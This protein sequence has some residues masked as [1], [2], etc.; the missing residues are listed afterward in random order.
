VGRKTIETLAR[1]GALDDFGGH[2]AQL[3][4]G[5]EAAWGYAQRT[6]ADDALGQSSLF[7]PHAGDG[8]GEI[9]PA[10]PVV[11]PWSRA[12]TLRN[13]RDLM[14]FYISGHPLEEYR[15]E[16][17]A[18][19]N[20]R[21]GDAAGVEPERDYSVVGIVTA[22]Q[23]RTSRAGKPMAFVSIEDDSGQ[24]EVA[25]FGQTYEKYASAL[26]VDDVLLVRGRVE[27]SGALRMVAREVVPMW[28][29][30]EQLVRAVVLKINADTTDAGRLEELYELCKANKGNAR[31][32]FEVTTKELPRMVRLHARSSVIDL[33][34][35]LMAGLVRLFGRESVVLEGV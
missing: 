11:E 10:L 23:R 12:E 8:A 26:V 7:G 20:L 5:V 31:L 3:V 17:K 18:F 33:S 16:T 21:L 29:V 2:R 19:A 6:Q 14:G 4:A 27:V 15:A 32:Y 28:R 25:L 24:A 30:R 34:P 1:A 9:R 35:D 13:E 22:V